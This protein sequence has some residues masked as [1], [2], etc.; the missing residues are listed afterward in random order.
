MDF[1]ING[2]L[3]ICQEIRAW[4]PLARVMFLQG[5]SPQCLALTGS[6]PVVLL[7]L[8][9]TAQKAVGTSFL[10]ILIISLSALAAHAKL[11]HVDYK[12]GILLGLGGI[13]G[14]QVGAHLVEHVSTASHKRV[15]AVLLVC[16]A[17][18]LWFKK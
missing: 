10:A 13:I 8:G 12:V 2:F 4:Q 5:L 3:L 6:I 14:A 18:T 17:T 7:Y 15:F 9:F 16:L 11:M 1:L